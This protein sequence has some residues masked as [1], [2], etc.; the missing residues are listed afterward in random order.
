[1]QSQIHLCSHKYICAV[2]STFVQSQVHLCSHKHICAVTSTF[3]QSQAHLCSQKYI[4]AVKSTFVQSQVHLCSHKYICAVTSTFVQSQVHLPGKK[5]SV[6]PARSCN[7]QFTGAHSITRPATVRAV[8]RRY[9]RGQQ[10]PNSCCLPTVFAVVWTA[11]VTTGNRL[12]HQ[13]ANCWLYSTIC[14]HWNCVLQIHNG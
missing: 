2:T 8:S 4:C 3:V 14:C 11:S 5:S 13:T 9:T 1:M 6:C 12:E 7:V 10:H